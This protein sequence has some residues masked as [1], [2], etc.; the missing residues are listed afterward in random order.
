[1]NTVLLVLQGINLV[2]TM[3]PSTLQAALE[4][5]KIF[6]SSGSDFSTQIQVFEAGA[7]KSAEETVA[8]I[9]AWKKANNY[10]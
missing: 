8:L 6:A 2:G 3:L 5:Q 9:D 4:L 10:V 7:L 1:M